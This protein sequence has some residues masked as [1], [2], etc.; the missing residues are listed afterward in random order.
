MPSPYPYELSTRVISALESKMSV[1][2]IMKVFK[3]R[4]D[5]VYKWKNIH[6]TTSDVMAQNGYR[7]LKYFVEKY[8][9]ICY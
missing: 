3:I 7:E 1:S 2:K 9:K 5:A 8:T 4:R 6:K